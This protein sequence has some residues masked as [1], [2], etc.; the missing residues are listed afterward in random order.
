[1]QICPFSKSNPIWSI[2]SDRVNLVALASP[3]H[4]ARYS[5]NWDRKLLVNLKNDRRW[6]LPNKTWLYLIRSYCVIICVECSIYN[7]TFNPLFD[8]GWLRYPSFSIYKLSFCHKLKYS[9]PISWQPNVVDLWYF[10]LLI[11]L[12][13]RI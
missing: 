3:V 4:R 13:Q 2:K 10:K 12:D 6:F 9:Y 11:L 1:M 7:G 8:Q 5:K